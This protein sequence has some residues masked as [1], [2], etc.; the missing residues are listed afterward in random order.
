VRS[1][2]DHL[3]GDEYAVQLTEALGEE[4]A[5]QPHN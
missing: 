1:L 2:S 5:Y 3:T 4:A